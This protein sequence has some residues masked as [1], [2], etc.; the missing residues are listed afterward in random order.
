MLPESAGGVVDNKFKV[1]GTKNVRVVDA[2]VLPIQLSAHLSSTLYGVA[3][4]AAAMIAAAHQ[5]AIQR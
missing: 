2:S 4:M 5:R 1:Y 3:I